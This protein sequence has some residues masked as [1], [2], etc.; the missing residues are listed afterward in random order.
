[1]QV[2]T[3][4]ITFMISIR[5]LMADLQHKNVT[6]QLKETS[7]AG[8]QAISP[9]VMGSRETMSELTSCCYHAGSSWWES[10]RQAR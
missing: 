8:Y 7:C 5:E 1:M 3:A 4:R 9:T 6:Y 2:Q 10:D